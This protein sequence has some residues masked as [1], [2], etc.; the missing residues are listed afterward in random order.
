VA[1]DRGGAVTVATRLPV[2]LAAGGGW[3]DTVLELP[4]GSWTDALTG[5]AFPGGPVEVGLLL[6]AYPVALLVPELVPDVVPEG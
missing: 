4:G 3:R 2:G 6:D 5:R 1:C